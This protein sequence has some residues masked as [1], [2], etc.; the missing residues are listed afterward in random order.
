MTTGR[1]AGILTREDGALHGVVLWSVS[2]LVVAWLVMS[3]VGTLVGGAFGV[4]SRTASAAV[5]GVATGA[6]QLA[7]QAGGIDFQALQR[8][9][10]AVLE[11]TQAP[12]LQ[13]DTLRAD[14]ERIGDR[15]TGPADN[16]QVARDI[17]ATIRERGGEVDREAIINV[18]TARTDM[19]RQEAERL[20]VR[21]ET[22]ASSAREELRVVAD[23][24]GAR[25]EE[26]AGDA[27]DAVSKGAWWALLTL[28]LS[29]AAAVGG[30]V[31]RAR[32]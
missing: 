19:N 12:G 27:S 10:E 29:L 4:V 13:P 18:I 9:I 8:E 28:G 21:V 23:T 14:A 15:A 5:G 6:G 20:A 11:Q 31:I 3:G 32:E 2:T 25:A 17:S 1:L 30:T 24:V 22:L 7:S 26:F 16:Q